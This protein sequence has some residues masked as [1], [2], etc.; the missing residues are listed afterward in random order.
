MGFDSLWQPV[1]ACGGLWWPVVAWDT[2][3]LVPTVKKLQSGGLQPG[4]LEAC[5]VILQP[6]GSENYKE[7]FGAPWNKDIIYN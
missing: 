3:V 6:G 5:M 4:G 1:V 2:G 7:A